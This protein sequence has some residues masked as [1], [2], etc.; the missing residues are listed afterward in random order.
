ME[1]TLDMHTTHCAAKVSYFWSERARRE[2]GRWQHAFLGFEEEARHEQ[3]HGLLCPLPLG[4][5]CRVH[6]PLPLILIFNEYTPSDFST[7]G[8]VCYGE[9]PMGA[10]EGRGAQ[11]ESSAV[12]TVSCS[13]TPPSYLL[14]TFFYLIRPIS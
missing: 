3:L 13:R 8:L 7:S 10:L 12:P 2:I 11:L 1:V 6:L 9:V 4:L 14:R 5:G